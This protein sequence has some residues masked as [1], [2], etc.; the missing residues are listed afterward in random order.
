MKL[1]VRLFGKNYF[2][3]GNLYAKKALAEDYYTMI[4]TCK[5]CGRTTTVSVKKGVHL[6]DIIT[7]VK[8]SNCECRL[9]KEK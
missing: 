1:R 3:E 8:C 6:N 4:V 9:E 2:T 7:G 5:N